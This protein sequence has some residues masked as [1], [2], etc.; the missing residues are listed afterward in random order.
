MKLTLEVDILTMNNWFIDVS[1]QVRDNFNGRTGGI[2]TL[3]KGIV[4]IILMGQNT[5]TIGAQQKPNQ[6]HK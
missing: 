1:H 2:M 5:N 3:E 6:G 4:A